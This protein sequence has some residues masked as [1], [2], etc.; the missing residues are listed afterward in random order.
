MAPVTVSVIVVKKRPGQ[1]SWW[2][3]PHQALYLLH[4]LLE[5]PSFS[6]SL[7]GLIF[8]VIIRVHFRDH[9]WCWSACMCVCGEYVEILTR[10]EIF[11]SP[12]RRKTGR[13]EECGWSRPFLEPWSDT[14]RIHCPS[15]LDRLSEEMSVRLIYVLDHETLFDCYSWS[16]CYREGGVSWASKGKSWVLIHFHSSSEEHHIFL[17]N[18]NDHT[19]RINDQQDYMR[20]SPHPYP[21]RITYIVFIML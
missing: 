10:L 8:M 17:E 21:N 1:S 11:S 15:E 2:K 3:L 19:L 20:S 18:C 16:I 5:L 7:L 9:W 14:R 13:R 6:W 4:L 12:G